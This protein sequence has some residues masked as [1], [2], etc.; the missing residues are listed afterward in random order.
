MKQLVLKSAVLILLVSTLFTACSQKKEVSSKDLKTIVDSASYCLG[1]NMGKQM[2]FEKMDIN[3]EVLMNAFYEAYQ[4]DT[5]FLIKEA[6]MQEVMMKYQ[7]GM[8]E[9]QR[10]DAIEKGKPN[11]E[12]G[13]KFLE[14]NKSKEGVQTT[15]TG[16]Q[17][18][19][20]KEGKGAK[21]TTMDR[22][23]IQYRL[24]T[25]DGKV[26]ESTYERG[27]EP[28]IMG[29]TNIIPG[30]VEGLQLMQEGGKYMLWISP[31]YGYGDMDSPELP[32][33]SVLCFE[34]DLIEVVKDSKVK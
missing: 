31:E 4:G 25:I 2:K 13:K 17:Y 16:I 22:V 20:L 10:A 8:E 15:A 32:A 9:K 21:P 29:L 26:V 3:P 5:N 28:V 1:A 19:V 12:K 27:Q 18:K 33:G 23:R 34:I 7:K 24:S 6:D 11:R 14:A 30:M